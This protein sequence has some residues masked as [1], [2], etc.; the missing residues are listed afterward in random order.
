MSASHYSDDGFWNKVGKYAKKAGASVLEPALKMYFSSKDGD[1]PLWAKS[2]IVGALGYFIFP[3]D[4]IPD[5]APVVG[6]S[7]DLG[8]LTS[9]VSVVAAYIK[10]EHVGEAKRKLKQWLS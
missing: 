10:D 8:V 6:Y 5:I 3:L 2:T 9:A 4:V 7:D 1:T